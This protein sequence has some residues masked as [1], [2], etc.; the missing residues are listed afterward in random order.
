M[1][2]KKI[3]KNLGTFLISVM[4]VEEFRQLLIRTNI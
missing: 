2:L 4:I 1:L 3:S